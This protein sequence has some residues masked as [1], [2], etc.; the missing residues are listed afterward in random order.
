MRL[1]AKDSIQTKII[2]ENFKVLYNTVFLTKRNRFQYFVSVLTL[3]NISYIGM[4]T[5][6]GDIKNYLKLYINQN[7]EM[8]PIKNLILSPLRVP[9]LYL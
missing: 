9:V 6:Y 3:S 8:I 4:L 2:D 1:N 5:F 7:N